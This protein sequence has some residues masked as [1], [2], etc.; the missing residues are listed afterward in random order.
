SFGT[1]G[2]LRIT[3]K[4]VMQD[5]DTRWSSTYAAVSRLLY[6]RRP[7]AEHKRIDSIAPLLEEKDWEVLRLVVEPLLK[8]FMTA[9]KHLEA[10]KEVTLSL[11]IPYIGDLWDDLEE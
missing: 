1:D 9:R 2:I 5:V 10:S 11:V 8:P 4:K 3:S 7:I 6:L